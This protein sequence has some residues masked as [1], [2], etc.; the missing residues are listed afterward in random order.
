MR[1][2]FRWIWVNRWWNTLGFICMIPKRHSQNKHGKKTYLI[3]RFSE[4]LIL[5]YTSSF[6]S[7]PLIKYKKQHLILYF[8]KEYYLIFFHILLKNITSNHL[9][10]QQFINCLLII[11]IIS[12]PSQMRRYQRINR[13][14]ERYKFSLFNL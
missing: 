10:I 14:F 11:S 8:E 7:F 1:M 13:W 9:L 6:V 4:V 12:L 2:L 3:A 5:Q